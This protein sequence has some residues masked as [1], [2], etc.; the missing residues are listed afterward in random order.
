MT[1]VGRP[2]R[3]QEIAEDLRHGGLTVGAGHADH[4]DPR[5]VPVKDG[6][7]PRHDRP[8]RPRRR[9]ASAR[10]PWEQLGDEVLA[11]QAD[12]AALHRLGGVDVPVAHMRGHAAEQ[13]PGHDSPAVVGDA[14][15]LDGGRVPDRLD[16]LDVVEE[17]VHGHGSHG[18]PDSVT[19]L[20]HPCVTPATGV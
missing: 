2:V 16:H 17:E 4:Q 12:G 18:R 13:V 6:G 7:E 10:C 11:Q 15:D 1:L 19:C 20:G 14:S 5:R 9:P 3:T 8:H